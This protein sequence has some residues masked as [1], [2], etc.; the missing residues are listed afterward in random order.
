[1]LDITGSTVTIDAIGCQKHMAEKVIENKADYVFGLKR[2]Q[3]SLLEYVKLY[4]DKETAKYTRLV[5]EKDHGRIEQR[6]YYLETKIYWLSQ[7]SDWVG[8]RRIGMVK[9]NV[10]ITKTGEIREECRYYLTSHNDV[11]AFAHAMRSHWSIENQL[12]WQLDVT[13]REDDSRAKKDNSPLNLNILRKESLRLLKQADFG[14]H[15]SIRR[16]MSRAA[17]YNSSLAIIFSEK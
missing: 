9:T 12:H 14:K 16:K 11:K 2:N 10:V 1:M 7:R 15:V 5:K 4:F 13:F 3:K 8:L 6:R 17:M